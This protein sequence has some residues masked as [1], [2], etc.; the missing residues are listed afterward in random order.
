MS[1]RW[2]TLSVSV[3]GC[4]SRRDGPALRQMNKARNSESG[5]EEDSRCS[6]GRVEIDAVVAF[7]RSAR[8][9]VCRSGVSLRGH[10]L[11]LACILHESGPLLNSIN[12]VKRRS[13]ELAAGIDG[14]RRSRSKF[15]LHPIQSGSC[16]RQGMPRVVAGLRK[17]KCG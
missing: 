10:I 5:G 7:S 1:D 11:R 3:A 15:H 13:E 4:R 14:A 2:S 16:G 12:T 9:C 8:G 6:V 17:V